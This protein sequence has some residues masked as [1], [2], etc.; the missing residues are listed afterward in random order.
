MKLEVNSTEQ[1]C[2]NMY[3]FKKSLEG[4]F[5]YSLNFL[6]KLNGNRMFQT[7]IFRFI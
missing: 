2:T 1:K 3:I 4:G 6:S 7:F 5:T